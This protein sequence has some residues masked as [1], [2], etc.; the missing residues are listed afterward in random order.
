MHIITRFFSPEVLGKDPGKDP[1]KDLGK[2]PGKDCKEPKLKM[3]INSGAKGSILQ[4]RR[5]S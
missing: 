3:K 4:R 1:G 2:D 5:I